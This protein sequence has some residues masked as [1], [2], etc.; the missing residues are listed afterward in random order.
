T[1]NAISTLGIPYHLFVATDEEAFISHLKERGDIGISY[2]HSLRSADN[3]PV[4]FSEGHRS[5]YQLGFEALLD[6]LLLSRCDFLLRTESNL[7]KVSEF[8]NPSI[9]SIDLSREFAYSRNDWTKPPKPNLES[10]RKKVVSAYGRKRE[11]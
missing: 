5:N 6:C 3:K 7:S 10:I 2:T 4:H 11:G 9:E 8:F 1:L